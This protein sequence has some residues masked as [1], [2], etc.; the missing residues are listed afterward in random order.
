MGYYAPAAPSL[1]F[2]NPASGDPLQIRCLPPTGHRIDVD[3]AVQ[4]LFQR[5][6]QLQGIDCH[7]RWAGVLFSLSTDR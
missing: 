7:D 4:R 2:H 3:L 5:P 6:Q 1:G